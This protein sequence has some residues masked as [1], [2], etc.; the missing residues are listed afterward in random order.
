MKKLQEKTQ[1]IITKKQIIKIVA[2]SRIW[3]EETAIHK[4]SHEVKYGWGVAVEK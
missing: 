4:V 1:P 2:L 3:D